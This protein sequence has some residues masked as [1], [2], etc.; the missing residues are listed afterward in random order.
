M[1]SDNSAPTAPGEGISAASVAAAS[2]SSDSS[3]Q[4]LNSQGKIKNFTSTFPAEAS[5]FIF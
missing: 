4:S 3:S 1:S 5:G 2:F